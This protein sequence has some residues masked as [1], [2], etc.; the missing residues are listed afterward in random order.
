[1]GR[2]ELGGVVFQSKVS[3]ARV[4]T[5]L[6]GAIA[7]SDYLIDGAHMHGWSRHQ[8]FVGEYRSRIRSVRIACTHW[9]HQ[10]A[11]G[12]IASYRSLL[13]LLGVSVKG[14]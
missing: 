11:I 3:L 12:V 5:G 7:A 2:V 10:F 1:M 9:H 4:I 6:A 8:M 14:V 13:F